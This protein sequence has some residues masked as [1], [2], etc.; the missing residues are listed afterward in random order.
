[1]SISRRLKGYEE[2]KEEQVNKHVGPEVSGPWLCI[3]TVDH[4]R[5]FMVMYKN[6]ERNKRLDGFF[7]ALNPCRVSERK[8]KKSFAHLFGPT[9]DQRRWPM[10]IC[11][12]WCVCTAHG[13]RSSLE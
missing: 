9:V 2:S 3:L 5:W 7:F 6:G 1:M 11:C 10:V 4:R 8:S 13:I 12:V